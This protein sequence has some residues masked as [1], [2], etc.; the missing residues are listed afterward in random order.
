MARVPD[1][2]C[3]ISVQK[4]DLFDVKDHTMRYYCMVFLLSFGEIH[5]AQKTD[6]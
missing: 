2:Q 3:S 4:I 6:L 5:N 1:M